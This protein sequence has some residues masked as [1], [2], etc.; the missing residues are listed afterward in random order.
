MYRPKTLCLALF[1]AFSM[2]AAAITSADNE[3]NPAEDQIRELMTQKRDALQERVDEMQK[4][5]GGGTVTTDK[6]LD[7]QL[8]LTKA[9]LELATSKEDR[10]SVLKSQVQ[11]FRDLEQAAKSR[12]ESGTALRAEVLN[13]KA[14]RLDAEI[15]LLRAQ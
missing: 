9:Q 6:V 10:L 3:A 2:T 8:D 7:A 4:L 1:V 13:A 5:H 15:A 12:Y 14:S 11:I